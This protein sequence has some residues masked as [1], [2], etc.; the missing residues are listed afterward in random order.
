M[1]GEEIS[2]ISVDHE[3]AIYCNGLITASRREFDFMWYLFTRTRD[4]ARRR[5]LLKALGCVEDEMILMRFIRRIIESNDIDNED[6]EWETILRATFTNGPLGLNV[7]LNFLRY[8]YDD[9]IGL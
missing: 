5:M 2:A 4:V 1:N 9:F 7:T 6:N 8:N 3:A